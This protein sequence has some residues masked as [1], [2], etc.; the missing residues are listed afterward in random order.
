[1]RAL[2]AP[3]LRYHSFFAEGEDVNRLVGDGKNVDVFYETRTTMRRR[4][5]IVKLNYPRSK[6]VIR[7]F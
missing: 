4:Q 6:E 5:H 1:M 2:R 3:R 7:R